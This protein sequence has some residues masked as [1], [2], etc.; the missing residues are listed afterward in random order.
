MKKA[1]L[2]ISASFLLA[3]CFSE[4]QPKE[5]V[6]TL[7]LGGSAIGRAAE[8]YVE[9]NEGTL[10]ELIYEIWLSG[11]SG[12]QTLTS[13][14]GDRTVQVTVVPGLYDIALEAHY[15][16][17]LYATGSVKGFVVKAGQR[18][19]AVIEM[20]PPEAVPVPVTGVSLNYTTLTL[21]AGGEPVILTATVE[22]VNAS[23]KT[24][25]WSSINTAVAT[26][27]VAGKV[28]GVSE[29][30]AAITVHTVD[31]GKTATCEVTVMGGGTAGLPTAPTGVKATASSTAIKISWDV[32]SG[33]IGYKIYYV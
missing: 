25:T 22:P 29:G 4:W 18:N 21:S 28:S 6:I 26:V 5:A 8:Y 12:E 3:A 9:P 32:V 2:I 10:N 24:V 17:I 33:A 15:G 11:P 27:D 7:K 19:T 30:T 23:N 20:R 1:L 31:G 16:E 14:Q 13:K